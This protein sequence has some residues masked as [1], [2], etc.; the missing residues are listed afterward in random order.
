MGERDGTERIQEGGS[1]IGCLGLVRVRD[2]SAYP[3]ALS[4][5]QIR[6]VETQNQNGP[7][8]DETKWQSGGTSTSFILNNESQRPP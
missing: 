4:G 2:P 7:N 1:A 3:T 5:L 8:S 6:S